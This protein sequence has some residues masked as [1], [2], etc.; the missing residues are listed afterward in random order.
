M[1]ALTNAEPKC[2][3]RHDSLLC[4]LSAVATGFFFALMLVLPT[5]F[6]SQ[7]GLLLAALLAGGGLFALNRWS[8][9]R[10]ILFLWLI[11]TCVG[12]FGIMWGFVNGAPGAAHVSSVFL[13]WPFV[14]MVFIGHV[15]SPRTIVVLEKV[16]CFGIAVASLMALSLLVA[17]VLGRGEWIR[18]VFAFQGAGIYVFDGF[19][20]LT[21]FNLATVIYGLPF[22][23]TLLFSPVTDGWLTNRRSLGILLLLVLAIC[24]VS[25]RRA[26]WL[27]AVA[28]PLL[29]LV[30]YFLA[31]VRFRVRYM[32]A[33][34]ILAFALAIGGV[35]GLGL[36]F[37]VLYEQ[38]L[39]AFDFSGEQSASLRY[40][41]YSALMSGWYEHP[42]IGQG[43]GAAEKSIVRSEEMV[44]AYELSYVALLFQTGIVG[45]IVYSSAVIWIFI[46]GLRIVRRQP[47]AVQV[48]LP[49]LAGLAGFLLVNATNPYLSKFDYLWTIF[50]PVAAINSYGTKR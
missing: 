21:L 14:Y 13:L 24:V 34:A 43:L 31:G 18:D 4:R 26:F 32:V 37:G 39:S 1:I 45:V 5:T 17:A 3:H 19:V 36:D 9:S 44:W 49:L 8:V 38:F 50:L 12:L 40:Q 33:T 23:A 10:D 35:I 29:V 20:E 22:L 2:S 27:L 16:L 11:T 30:L 6:Q 47:D 42:L 25:G 7:R 28:T 48:I 41:Q 15:H 46:T